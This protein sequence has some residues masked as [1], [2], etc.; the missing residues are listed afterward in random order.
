MRFL[1]YN[2][3]YGAGIG[4]QIH[5]PLPYI[6]YLKRTNGNFE[7]IAEFIRTIGPDIAGLIEVDCGSYRTEQ[8]NQASAVARLMDHESV[9]QS[10]YSEAS[11]LQKVPLLNKQGNAILTN[12]Y[13]KNSHFH[14]FSIGIKRLV[15][16]M[17]LEDCRIFLVHLSL[18]FRQR[19][20][21][22]KELQTFLSGTQKPLIVAGDFN[23]FRGDSE[24]LHF[25]SGANLKSANGGGHPS[26][27]SRAP[28][29]YTH[30]TL[31]T[32]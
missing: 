6:G 18:R 9:Y 7:R 30:L 3:R 11:L 27:P 2:I 17:E 25:M 8:S 31:P 5:F 16:E 15:L 10:K 26:H 23:V 1:L 28:V 32:N 12:R 13:V 20:T 22:L 24:L 14:Y 29:S 4:R 21:Q 19:Q